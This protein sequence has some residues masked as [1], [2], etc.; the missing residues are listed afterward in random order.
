MQGRRRFLRRASLD[1]KPSPVRLR[2]LTRTSSSRGLAGTILG[3]ALV[4][5]GCQEPPPP[6][7][8]QLY[9]KV[10][11]GPGRPTA[12][13]VVSRSGKELGRTGPDGRALGK[14]P[15]A[16][17]EIV[18]VGVTCPEGYAPPK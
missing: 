6:A 12:G 14:R 17:G 13:A 1:P 5:A 10:E 18:D 8:Y 7:P 15:G 16:E 9:V 2:G 3:L 4:G 11:S